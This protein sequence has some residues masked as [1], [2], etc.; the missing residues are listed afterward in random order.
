MNISIVIPTYNE[1]KYISNCLT[2]L[3]SQSLKPKEIIIVDDGSTDKTLKA[4]SA[5][6]IRSVK[7]KI[8]SQNHKG[9]GAARN[10]GVKQAIGDILVFVDADMEF[11]RDFIKNLTAPI[12]KG[13]SKGTFSKD[14]FVKNWDNQW[15]KAWNRCIGLN[16]NRAIPKRFPKK[17]PVFRAILKTEFDL[18]G[19]FDQNRG[20]DDD[21]SLSEKLKYKATLAPQAIYYHYNPDTPIEIFT[22]AKWRSQRKYKFGLV[23]KIITLIKTPILTATFAAPVWYLI[24]YRSIS[25]LIGKFIFDSGTFVG[26]ITNIISKKTSK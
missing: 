17:S 8:I 5:L 19:G 4:L 3:A 10:K 9:A 7:L 26:L 16:S 13:K 12:R 14:E 15:A 21:W 25:S 2:S 20:Y 22:Q 6:K 11:D 23:G 18:V 1:E 24:R